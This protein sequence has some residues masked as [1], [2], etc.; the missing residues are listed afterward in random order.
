VGEAKSPVFQ[1]V[2]EVEHFRSGPP[3][4]LPRAS[5]VVGTRLGAFGKHRAESGCVFDHF[6]GV[7]GGGAEHGAISFGHLGGVRWCEVGAAEAAFAGKL[8][9]VGLF[10]DTRTRNIDFVGAFGGLLIDVLF[11][12]NVGVAGGVDRRCGVVEDERGPVGGQLA[13]RAGLGLTPGGFDLFEARRD[14]GS[15]GGH[16]HVVESLLGVG[17]VDVAVGDVSD[18]GAVLEHGVQVR[19]VDIGVAAAVGVTQHGQC[20][21]DGRRR[22]SARCSSSAS[23][24]ASEVST[25]LAGSARAGATAAAWRAP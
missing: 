23:A 9:A 1:G 16:A 3:G 14:D 20:R 10:G 18:D 15:F 6:V 5:C 22:F 13:I 25:T 11:G 12:G 21:V 17:L 4:A 7:Q 8:P 24:T 2:V 19:L